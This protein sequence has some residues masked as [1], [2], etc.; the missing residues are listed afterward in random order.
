M[1]LIDTDLVDR[2]VLFHY[3]KQRHG[4]GQADV[5]FLSMESRTSAQSQ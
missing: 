2:R 1:P 5:A 3:S 4:V